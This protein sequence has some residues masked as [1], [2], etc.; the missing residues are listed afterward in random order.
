VEKLTRVK[1]QL[2]Q[3]MMVDQ[4]GELCFIM[5]WGGCTAC[6]VNQSMLW[7]FCWQSWAQV[8]HL[9]GSNVW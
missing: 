1:Q 6:I 5:G 2:L 8:D 4:K 9:M 7:P 3:M